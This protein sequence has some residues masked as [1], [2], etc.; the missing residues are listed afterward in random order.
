MLPICF[1]PLQVSLFPALGSKELTHVF[2]CWVRLREGIDRRSGGWEERAFGVV[3]S[4]ALPCQ[5]VSGWLHALL[6]ATPPV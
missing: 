1:L 6:T 2:S 4:W 5:A 3:I